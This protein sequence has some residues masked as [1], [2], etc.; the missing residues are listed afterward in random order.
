MWDAFVA[1]IFLS[2]IPWLIDCDIITKKTGHLHNL[3]LKRLHVLH[4]KVRFQ[5]YFSNC[6]KMGY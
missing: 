3:F 1:G 6:N 4:F 5:V 2:D